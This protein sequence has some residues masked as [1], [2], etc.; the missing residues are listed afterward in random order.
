MNETTTAYG[1]G[2]PTYYIDEV[3]TE[4]DRKEN[5]TNIIIGLISLWVV[6]WL[7]YLLGIYL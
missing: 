4:L 7:G 6:F 5:R 2:I 3:Y 1:E